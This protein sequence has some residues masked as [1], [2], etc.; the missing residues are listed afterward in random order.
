MI[1]SNSCFTVR[2]D[3]RRRRLVPE[4][5]N[6]TMDERVDAIWN[7][8]KDVFTDLS[9]SDAFAEGASFACAVIMR[10]LEHNFHIC[11]GKSPNEC[12]QLFEWT[13]MDASSYASAIAGKIETEETCQARGAVES[14]S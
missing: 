1:A 9:T 14:N 12:R 10:T 4:K 7:E 11:K 6:P 2:S 13:I 3:A 5:E 8:I